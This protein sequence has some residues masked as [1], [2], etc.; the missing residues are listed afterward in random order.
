MVEEDTVLDFE[1]IEVTVNVES[2]VAL[3]DPDDVFDKGGLIVSVED[4]VEDFEEEVVRVFD[5][6]ILID[7]VVVGDCVVDL[8]LV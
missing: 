5:S 3:D 4:V 1:N 2:E 8:E 6:V 7:P